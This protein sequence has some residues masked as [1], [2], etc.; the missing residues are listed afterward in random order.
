MTK[1]LGKNIRNRYISAAKAELQKW[2]IDPE[3]KTRMMMF[4][5]LVGMRLNGEDVE[6]FV[7]GRMKYED[8]VRLVHLPSGGVGV[9]APG[10]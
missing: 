3:E 10:G 7:N 8:V 5:V 9:Q 4:S 2:R 1:P 6:A